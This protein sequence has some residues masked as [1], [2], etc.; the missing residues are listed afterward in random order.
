MSSN[1]R[2]W[3]IIAG[4]VQIIYQERI[5]KLITVRIVGVPALLQRQS[6]VH[7]DSSEDMADSTKCSSL[8]EW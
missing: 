1:H 3:K 5:S 6:T 4:V 2:S 7:P 8:I